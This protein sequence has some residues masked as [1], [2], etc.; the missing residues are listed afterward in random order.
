MKIRWTASAADDLKSAHE[1]IDEESSSAADAL[2]DQIF[3][4]IEMLQRFP[5]AGRQ[6][7]IE[8]TRELVV[9]GTP[10]IIFYRISHDHIEILGIIHAARRWP[11]SL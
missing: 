11:S 2:I 6:G 10:F 5:R 3:A 4:G 7:R 1:Y 8:N 9:S